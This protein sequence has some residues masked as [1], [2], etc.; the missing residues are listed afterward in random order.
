MLLVS[1]HVI[2]FTNLPSFL[3]SEY[4]FFLFNQ[5]CVWTYDY[6]DKNYGNIFYNGRKHI[7]F[8]AP[9]KVAVSLKD[10]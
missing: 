3:K 8:F 2:G 5:G 6:T 10:N 7:W 1:L 4:N 9:R